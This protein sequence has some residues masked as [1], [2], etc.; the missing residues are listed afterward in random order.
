ML[1][2]LEDMGKGGLRFA[3][4]S[5]SGVVVSELIFSLLRVVVSQVWYLVS[6]IIHW[7]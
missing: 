5:Q 7:L 6:C 3:C 4:G 2:L 1:L